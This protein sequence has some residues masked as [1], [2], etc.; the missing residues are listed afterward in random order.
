MKL[1]ASIAFRSLVAKIR[2]FIYSLFLAFDSSEEFVRG[3]AAV[4]DPLGKVVLGV[5]E[6]HFAIRALYLFKDNGLRSYADCHDVGQLT[7]FLSNLNVL[8]KHGLSAGNGPA[9]SHHRLAGR[10]HP[11]FLSSLFTVVGSPTARK[12]IELINTRF[13]TGAGSGPQNYC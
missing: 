4:D 8:G 10:L 13:L 2:P 12:P 5:L 11:L 9:H 3:F 6:H 7:I 1:F